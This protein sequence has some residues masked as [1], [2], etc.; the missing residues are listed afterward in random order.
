MVEEKDVS[1]EKTIKYVI[2]DFQINLNYAIFASVSF[3]SDA[4]V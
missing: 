2:I 4:D 3:K 1:L